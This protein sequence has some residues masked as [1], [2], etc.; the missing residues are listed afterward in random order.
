MIVVR[1]RWNTN[2]DGSEATGDDDPYSLVGPFESEFAAE[3]YMIDGYPDD[4]TDIE[5]MFIDHENIEYTPG[6]LEN[7]NNPTEY[8]WPADPENI[9][10]SLRHQQSEEKQNA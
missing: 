2:A 3:W 8:M 6:E 10:A 7:M 4:D 9:P 5:D 1:I